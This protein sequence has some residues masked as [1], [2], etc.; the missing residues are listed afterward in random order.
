MK[1]NLKVLM[2][3]WIIATCFSRMPVFAMG[4]TYDLPELG[5]E[6]S[7]P[8][9]YAVIT[10]DT[11]EED[12][13]FSDLGTTK[14]DLISQY[15]ANNIYLNAVAHT[16]D[17]EIV[18][19]MTENSIS[20]FSL[21]SDTELDVW[22]TTLLGQLG[23]Y[24]IS[25]SKYEIYHHS[26]AKFIKL[27]FTDAANNAHGLQY[28]T[29]YEGKAMNFVM[30]SYKGNLSSEQEDSLKTIVD[31]IKYTSAPPVPKTGEDTSSFC[32]YDEHSGLSFTVPANWRQEELSKERETLDAKFVSTKEAGCT[33]TYGSTDLWE[34][35]PASD[36]IGS[37][38]EDFN[39]SMFEI[40]DMAEMYGVSADKITTVTYNNI[41]YFKIEITQSSELY[42]A[43]FF[44]TMTQIARV[45]NGWMYIFQFGGAS[46]HALYSEFE[47]LLNSVQYS[48][49]SNTK[50]GES[51]VNSLAIDTGGE[52]GLITLYLI[53]MAAI[54][55]VVVLVNKKNAKKTRNISPNPEF[56]EVDVVEK[57]N[58]PATVACKNC[59]QDLPLDSSF[60]HICGHKNNKQ[61]DQL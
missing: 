36:K 21:F 38:R 26:Q 20:N 15:E 11:P 43:D 34:S 23:D 44:V 47:N 19:T 46:D 7:V 57:H 22:A 18:V 16:L 1:K 59:G 45:E 9:E 8:T 5:L 56:R 6:V 61:G 29:V 48:A 14:K 17:E 32:Y 13:V 53:I 33:I 39:S 37:S 41:P 2:I 12:A 58:V 52:G 24:G 25:V 50:Q 42:G 60:C 35:L 3:I 55:M 40:A 27:Y 10:R 28:Y 54:I 31:S 30:R 4:S 49:T 51:I